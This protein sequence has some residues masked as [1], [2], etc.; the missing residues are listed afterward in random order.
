MTGVAQLVEHPKVP[1]YP[2]W[3]RE[4]VESLYSGGSNP[5]MGTSNIHVCLVA[6]LAA[7]MPLEHGVVGS[8][9]TRATI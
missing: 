3:Q 5:P 7:H 4:Q 9:P 2:N 1:V 8:I 6:Q